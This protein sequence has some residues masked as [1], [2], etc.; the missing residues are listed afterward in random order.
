[1]TEQ[2]F[3]TLENELIDLDYKSDPWT[4]EDL[5]RQAEIMKLLAEAGRL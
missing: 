1:M 2:E 4:Q 5:D 3:E